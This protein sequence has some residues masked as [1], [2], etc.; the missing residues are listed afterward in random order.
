[1]IT[2]TLVEDPSLTDF[3]HCRA[4]EKLRHWQSVKGSEWHDLG[5]ESDL[6][7]GEDGPVCR[8]EGSVSGEPGERHPALLCPEKV[9][10][11]YLE[12]CP[13]ITMFKKL[14]A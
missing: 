2:Q 9:K 1:M 6:G 14:N 3:E 10:R 8:L 5:L 11:I 13:T 12:N 7:L 4:G